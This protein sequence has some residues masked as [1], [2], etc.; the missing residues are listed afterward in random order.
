MPKGKSR[1]SSQPRSWLSYLA[2]RLVEELVPPA[3]RVAARKHWT[4]YFR[5]RLAFE[6]GRRI[7]GTVRDL[8][9]HHALTLPCEAWAAETAALAEKHGCAE[10]DVRASVWAAMSRTADQIK[11]RARSERKSVPGI[12]RPRATPCRLSARPW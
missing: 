6:I 3:E 9:H 2:A 10:V 8:A 4:P 1:K 12:T 7:D 11:A 5:N